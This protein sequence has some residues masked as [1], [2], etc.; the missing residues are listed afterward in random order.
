M[1]GHG[2]PV[3]GRR[4]GGREGRRSL[5]PS[6]P[7]LAVTAMLIAGVALLLYPT[8]AGW[9]NSWHQSRAVSTYEDAV[10]AVSDAESVLMLQAA[11]EYN[12]E[13]LESGH[14]L[15]LTEDE[16]DEYESLLSVN[17]TSA[18]GYLE[19]PAIGV[20]LPIYHGTGEG[21]LQSG[22]GHLEG[23]SLPVGGP[24]THAVLTGHTGL[25]S[26]R[27]LTDLDELEAGD[28]FYVH[29]LGETLAYEVDQVLVVLPDEVD[30]LAIEEGRDLCTLVTCTPYGVNDHRLLVRGHRVSAG[31]AVEAQ[32]EAAGSPLDAPVFR[33][34]VTGAVVS[35]AALVVT[36][37]AYV[38]LRFRKREGLDGRARYPSKGTRRCPSAHAWSDF[39]RYSRFG[40]RYGD[41]LDDRGPVVGR[42]FDVGRAGD[43]RPRR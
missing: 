15:G 16:L 2:R 25:S 35:S 5:R 8:V 38:V 28:V 20:T 37:V 14:G 17:G 13:L 1:A 39:D 24:G 10:S 31:E 4:G 6:L 30:A 26:S 32:A 27:L 19:V 41:G 43:P 33:A 42:H 12:Q 18:M 11:R 40:P 36:V 29:V 34:L 9:W 3:P 22:V 21:S 7:T 23:S